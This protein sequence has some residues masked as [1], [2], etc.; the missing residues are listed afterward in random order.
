MQQKYNMDNIRLG[1]NNHDFTL[2][3][4]QQ[5]FEMRQQMLDRSQYYVIY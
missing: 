4:S 1:C 3:K 2:N 5:L